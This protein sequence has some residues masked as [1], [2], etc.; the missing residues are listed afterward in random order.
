[1]DVIRDAA[2]RKKRLRERATSGLVLVLLDG[3]LGYLIDE[4]GRKDGAGGDT[5]Y[6]SNREVTLDMTPRSTFDDVSHCTFGI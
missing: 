2:V 3:W 1:V 6:L 4:D 5:S